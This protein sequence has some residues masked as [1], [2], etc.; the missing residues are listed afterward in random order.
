MSSSSLMETHDGLWMAIPETIPGLCTILPTLMLD[1]VL[2]SGRGVRRVL[3]LGAHCDDIEIGCGATLLALQKRANLAIDWVV[4]SGTPERRAETRKAMQ[5]LIRPSARGA[6]I[7]GDFE[8]GRFPGQ[9]ADTKGFVESLK[10]RMKSP[11]IILTHERDDR[12]QDHRA[13]NELV[14]NTFRDHVV[15][16]YEIPKWDGG[17]GQPNMYVPV[18]ARE[19]QAKVDALLASHRSQRKRD[20]FTRDTFMSLLRL[21]GLECRSPS[22]YAE[23]FHGR[24]LRISG[25]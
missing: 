6:L 15:L 14:W 1:L 25:V 12:H 21:R 16:E 11:D 2:K 7:F 5:L 17:L 22:G 13:V 19:A 10:S 9:Y 18:T 23:G 8:D 4:L 20:W 3:C 24:K